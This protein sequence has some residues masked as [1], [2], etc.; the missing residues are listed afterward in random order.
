FNNL[1]QV[2]VWE[3]QEIGLRDFTGLNKLETICKRL[4]V[5]HSPKLLTLSGLENVSS[6]LNNISIITNS[7]L[8]NI[9]ALNNITSVEETIFI[10]KNPYLTNCS[11]NS[12]CAHLVK[13]GNLYVG[14]NSAGCNNKDEILVGCSESDIDDD[15]DGVMNNLDLCPDTPIDEI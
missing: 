12:V 9:N 11:I 3:V 15:M 1:K 7:L 13:S 8:N 14:G 2:D 4:N 10:Q 5:S 6:S